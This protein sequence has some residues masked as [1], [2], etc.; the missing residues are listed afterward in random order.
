MQEVI[1]FPSRPIEHS[2]THISEKLGKIA[3]KANCL[4]LSLLFSFFSLSL[5]MYH[6][7]E[8]LTICLKQFL[9]LVVLKIISTNHSSQKEQDEEKYVNE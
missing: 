4:P 1:H 2:Q 6:Q 7:S 8:F 3:E 5:Y 9:E